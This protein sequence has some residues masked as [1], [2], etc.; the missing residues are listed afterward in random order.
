MRSGVKTLKR[1][2][3]TSADNQPQPG[4]RF[5]TFEDLEAYQVA[6]EFRKAM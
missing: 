6:R 5:Q 2:N 3:G 4:R 1:Y